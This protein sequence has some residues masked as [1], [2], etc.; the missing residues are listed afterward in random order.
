MKIAAT[1]GSRT[2]V[3]ANDGAHGTERGNRGLGRLALGHPDRHPG[4]DRFPQVV[5]GLGEDQR[6][7]GRPQPRV[8][9][10]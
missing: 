5:F 10:G 8:Q 9:F 4:L 3:R 1:S 6:G 2:A 7:V